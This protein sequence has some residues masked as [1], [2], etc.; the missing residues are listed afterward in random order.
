VIKYL[1]KIGV[2]QEEIDATRRI[3]LEK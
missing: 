3:L 1:L 2:T